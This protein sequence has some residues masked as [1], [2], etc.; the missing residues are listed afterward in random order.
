MRKKNRIGGIML[1]NRKLYQEA[2]VIKIVWYWH[3]N[4]NAD[5]WNNIESPEIKPD[6]YGQLIYDKRGKS[7]KWRKNSLF[8]LQ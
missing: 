2:M 4:R 3:K 8:N 7:V 6:T 1:S 5:Q